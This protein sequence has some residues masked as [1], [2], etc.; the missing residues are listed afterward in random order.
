MVFKGRIIGVIHNWNMTV[1]L[2]YKYV[3]KFAEGDTWYTTE[4][5]DV[6]SSI[7]FKLK[8]SKKMNWD[9]SMAKASLS[10]YL[11]KKYK[12]QHIKFLR[13]W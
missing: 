5:N 7:S 6:I 9:H 8:K 3:E 2:G 10:D 12:F 1:D 11:S 13:L 4:S